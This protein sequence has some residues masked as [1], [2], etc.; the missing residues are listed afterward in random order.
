MTKEEFMGK[1]QMAYFGDKNALNECT[2]AISKA[3]AILQI[4]IR[5]YNSDGSRKAL[6]EV[7]CDVE[8]ILK[9]VER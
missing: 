9:G 6:F 1:M 4:G 8:N 3:I 2:Q 5:T 7:I